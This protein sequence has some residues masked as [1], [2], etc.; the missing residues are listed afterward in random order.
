[1]NH[2]R[3]N[4][5]I[6]GTDYLATLQPPGEYCVDTVEAVPMT[7]LKERYPAEG[8]V[9]SGSPSEVVDLCTCPKW[10][11]SVELHPHMPNFW[12]QYPKLKDYYEAEYHP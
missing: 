7:Q 3:G 5:W 8:W 9:G 1:V 2:F 4:F 12:R 10:D 11:H 6:A